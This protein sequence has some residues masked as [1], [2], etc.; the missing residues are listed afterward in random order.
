[1][2][3]EVETQIRANI[4]EVMKMS[5]VREMTLFLA[6][7]LPLTLHL[8]SVVKGNPAGS[9]L[10]LPPLGCPS[11]SG[12]TDNGIYPRLDVSQIFRIGSRTSTNSES[13]GSHLDL[14]GG[15]SCG[16]GISVD[17]STS[18]FL[19]D[20]RSN[21]A[22]KIVEIVPRTGF[23]GKPAMNSHVLLAHLTNQGLVSL[24]SELLDVVSLADVHQ[25]VDEGLV[26]RISNLVGGCGV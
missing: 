17:R 6:K 1:M 3:Y 5:R 10:Q 15:E 13:G 16:R 4:W 20:L 7:Y 19:I 22:M 14:I 8:L 2:M 12:F 23:V 26:S 25:E 21:L 9:T 18:K 24:P 11:A